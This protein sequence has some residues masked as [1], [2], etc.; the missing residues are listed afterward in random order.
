MSQKEYF[1]SQCTASSPCPMDENKCGLNNSDFCS[2]CK[3]TAEE[4]KDWCSMTTEQK[5]GICKELLDR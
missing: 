4:I 2:L 3:R 5:N 1:I